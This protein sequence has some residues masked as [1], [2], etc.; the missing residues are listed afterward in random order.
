MRPLQLQIQP[1]LCEVIRQVK[2]PQSLGVIGV[3]A[4]ARLG[5]GIRFIVFDLTFQSLC[6]SGILPLLTGSTGRRTKLRGRSWT[7]R[8]GR[9]GTSI[10]RW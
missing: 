8:R 4:C 1:S 2:T 10:G 9:S 5:S 3:C 6:M 7:A